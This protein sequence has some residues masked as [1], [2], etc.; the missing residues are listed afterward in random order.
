MPAK[1]RGGIDKV[2]N[3]ENLAQ[4]KTE[5]GIDK[6]RAEVARRSADDLGINSVSGRGNTTSFRQDG[7]PGADIHIHK[8]GDH[9]DTHIHRHSD[10]THSFS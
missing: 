10:A 7:S 8:Y 4:T 5:K 1:Q 2:T 6:I 3:A 9:A